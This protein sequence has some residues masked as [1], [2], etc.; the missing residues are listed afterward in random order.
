MIEMGI[1]TTCIGAFPKPAYVPVVDWFSPEFGSDTS[2]ATGLYKDLLNATGEAAEDLFVSATKEVICDQ[3]NSGIDIPTDGE[4]RRENYIHYHCRHMAGIDFDCLTSKKL[5][6]GAY[7]TRLPTITGPI[8]PNNDPFLAHDYR[9]AQTFTDCPV[10]VTI[11]GPLT[12][13]D[14]T[15]DNYYGDAIELGNDL[16]DAI[17]FE[18]RALAD[19]GCRYIQ[20]DEP[21]FARNVKAAL[22]FGIDHLNRCFHGLESGIHRVVHICCGYPRFL[23][24]RDYHK[25]DPQTYFDLAA[26]LDKAAIDQISIEDAHRHNDLTLLEKFTESAVILGVVTVAQSRVET[27]EEIRNRLL[28]ALHHIDRHRLIAAPDCGLGLLG[29]DLAVRKL[30]NL[31]KAAQTI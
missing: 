7:E 26:A 28:S 13:A 15:M 6:D 14:T 22:D 16:A 5:R 18:V 19:A 17:N 25:A 29:R 24:E 30:T 10:K 23:D 8:K 4:V 2:R 3:V 9:I 31:C 12:I 11:P 27:I 1:L 21:L 20:I